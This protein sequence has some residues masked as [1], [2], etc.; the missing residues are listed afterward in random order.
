MLGLKLQLS[1]A[2]KMSENR[3]FFFNTRT[4]L[5]PGQD[6]CGAGPPSCSQGSWYLPCCQQEGTPQLHQAPSPDTSRTC[7]QQGGGK[8]I[9]CEGNSSWKRHKLGVWDAEE[10]RRQHQAPFPQQGSPLLPRTCRHCS[11]HLT[12]PVMGTSTLQLWTLSPPPWQY[13]PKPSTTLSYPTSFW[14]PHRG[15]S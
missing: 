15:I 6:W 5:S 2:L 9:H 1:D 14:K 7:Y 3:T 8:G 10:V 13:A 11:S 4:K 12:T